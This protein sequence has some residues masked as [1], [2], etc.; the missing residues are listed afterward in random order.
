MDPSVALGSA[1]Y[2]CARMRLRVDQPGG[3]SISAHCVENSSE[4][5]VVSLICDCIYVCR[6]LHICINYTTLCI[7]VV[8]C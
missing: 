2:Q 8:Y 4:M 1:C 3:G 5:D 7:V 6:Y